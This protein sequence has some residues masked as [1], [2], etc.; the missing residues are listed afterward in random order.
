M[1]N[2]KQ[3]FS[4]AVNWTQDLVPLNYAWNTESS[5]LIFIIR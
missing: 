2:Y 3:N 4:D 1:E 5:L